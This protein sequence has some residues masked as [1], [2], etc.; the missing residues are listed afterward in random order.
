MK[1]FWVR[2]GCVY[3]LELEKLFSADDSKLKNVEKRHKEQA[4]GE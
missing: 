3:T 4:R 2:Q 1:H